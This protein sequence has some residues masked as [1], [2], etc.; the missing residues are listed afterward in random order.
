[1]PRLLAALLMLLPAQAFAEVFAPRTATLDNGMEVVVI[2]NHRAPI[3]THMVWYRVGAI[4]EP[5]GQ[6][7]IAHL[8]EHMMF[9]GTDTLAPGEFS[10]TVSLNG[11]QENAFTGQDYTAY[12]QN[13]AVD[14]LGAMMA[15]EADRMVNVRFDE[16]NF[17]TERDV[18][19][20][21]RHARVDASPGAQLW[22]RMA[23]ALFPAHPYGIPIIGWEHEVST[24]EREAALDFYRTWYRPNNAILVVA[25]AVT[26]EQVLDLAADTYAEVPPSEHPPR[27]WPSQP[28]RPASTTITYPHPQVRQPH[29]QVVAVAPSYATA[30]DP[31]Q[32][33]ALQVLAKALGQGMTSRLHQELVVDEK[34]ATTVQVYY[35]AARL[36]ESTFSVFASPTPGVPVEDLREAL[37]EALADAVEDGFSDAEVADAIRRLRADV[38]FLRDNPE[39]A[40]NTVGRM[41]VTGSTVEDIEAWPDRI[42]AVTPEQVAAVA[43]LVLRDAARVT[44]ILI[45]AADVPAEG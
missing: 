22:E 21:E 44:G 25:G 3:V 17:L 41:L 45:P 35:D 42:A 34:L 14:R 12:Y 16:Q 15:L 9:K 36:A 24:L 27:V 31:M 38:V 11:G 18:V 8:L 5:P 37:D 13:V 33:M 2:E 20:E 39:R 32:P 4:D 43:R 28:M 30:Q 7:G 29:V 19:I 40:A 6:S 26:L 23:R 10:K 1:M